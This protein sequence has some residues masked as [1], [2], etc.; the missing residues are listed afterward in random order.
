MRNI[1]G[2][3]R[4]RDVKNPVATVWLIPFRE[5]RHHDRLAADLLSFMPCVGSKNV[6]RSLLPAALSQ[7]KMTYTIWTLPGS[8]LHAS[9]TMEEG[10]RA[11]C[12]G[13]GDS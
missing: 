2:D 8:D 7:W 13:N 12:A 10:R 5:L 6:P 3:S 11:K 9:K 4:Y 1:R